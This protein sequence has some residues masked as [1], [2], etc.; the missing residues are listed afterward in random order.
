MLKIIERRR[1][2]IIHL[3]RR[4]QL[5]M[6]ISLFRAKNSNQFVVDQNQEVEKL[7]FTIDRN[8][9]LN[10]LDVQQKH[11]DLVLSWISKLNLEVHE[12]FYEDLFID[13]LG[14]DLAPNTFN[15]IT[16]FL[17]HDINEIKLLPKTQRTGIIGYRNELENFNEIE[18][19]L[20]ETPYHASLID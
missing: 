17:G 12:V 13:E 8:S 4:D 7:T 15:K 20:M 19:A 2:P 18:S 9:L 3:R 6:A 10:Q 5:A 16:R 14:S 1:T 11:E